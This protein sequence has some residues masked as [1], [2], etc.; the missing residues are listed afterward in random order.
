[1][2]ADWNR[3]EVE[4]GQVFHFKNSLRPFI[5]VKDSNDNEL[6]LNIEEMKIYSLDELETEVLFFYRI[7]DDDDFLGVNLDG[8]IEWVE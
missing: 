7:D 8:H 4:K 5:I 6:F 1:M 3:N 2:I